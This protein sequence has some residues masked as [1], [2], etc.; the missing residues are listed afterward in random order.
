MLEGQGQRGQEAQGGGGG[1]KLQSTPRGGHGYFWLLFLRAIRRMTNCPL[2]TQPCCRHS[3]WEACP[4]LALYHVKALKHRS[5]QSHS[6]EPSRG[7]RRF[8]STIGTMTALP[9]LQWLLRPI[10]LVSVGNWQR[11]TGSVGSPFPPVSC[12][13]HCLYVTRERR[14]AAS[15]CTGQA[16][17]QAG[18]QKAVVGHV[19]SH[20]F[21][22]ALDVC[23]DKN[24]HFVQNSV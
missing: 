3:R 21:F 16:T 14:A 5:T 1:G 4:Q 19:P 11:E 12:R 23:N 24:E 6:T 15:P 20:F 7:H 13:R 9:P 17:A 10:F 22:R 18:P 8:F 2:I